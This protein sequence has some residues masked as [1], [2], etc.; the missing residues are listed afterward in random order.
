MKSKQAIIWALLLKF[1]NLALVVMVSVHE[2]LSDVITVA[3]N[4]VPVGYR[5]LAEVLRY[6]GQSY[7][8]RL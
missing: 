4:F 2:V 8:S 3:D 6:G 5:I 1:G 7:C